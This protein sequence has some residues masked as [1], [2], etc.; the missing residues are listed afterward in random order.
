MRTVL[1]GIGLLAVAF[2]L[3]VPAA[4]DDKKDAAKTADKKDAPK[5]DAAFNIDKRVTLDDKQKAQLEEL[6]KEFGPKLKEIQAKIDVVMTPDRKKIAAEARKK[7]ADDGKKGKEISEA[8]S[9]ALNLNAEDQAKLKE[10]QA[11]RQKLVK[12]INEKKM[13]LLTEEQKKVVQTKPK[14]K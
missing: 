13:G 7:A 12:E 11:E 1:R 14:N 10:A 2:L 8:V 6:M 5:A 3:A 9:A 4:A